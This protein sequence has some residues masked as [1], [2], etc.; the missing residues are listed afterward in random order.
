MNGK[1]KLKL[2]NGVLI[3]SEFVENKATGKGKKIFLNKSYYE[4]LLKNGQMNG[5]GKLWLTDDTS[6]EGYWKNDIPSGHMTRE[7]KSYTLQG[8]FSDYTKVSGQMW[9]KKLTCLDQTFH[10]RGQLKDTKI[11]GKGEFKWPD[12]RQ[13]FGEFFQGTMNGQGKLLWNDK[14]GGKAI[15]K[16]I[17]II[18]QFHGNGR[19]VWS[20]GDIYSGKKIS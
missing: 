18:N 12:G 2:T 5:L 19:L 14:Y 4:G 8:I 11:D 1:G 7:G 13:Y 3:D 6:Y 9:I 10:Y 16:G 20:N 15:Y 17:F